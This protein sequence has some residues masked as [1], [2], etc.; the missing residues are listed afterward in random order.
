[1]A[2][3][4][5]AV[6]LPRVNAGTLITFRRAP[7]E[8]VTPRIQRVVDAAKKSRKGATLQDIFKS[9]KLDTKTAFQDTV[10]IVRT[11]AKEGALQ[12]KPA[13][14]VIRQAAGMPEPKV[15]PVSIGGPG[16]YVTAK[17]IAVAFSN[18]QTLGRLRR[19]LM[20]KADPRVTQALVRSGLLAKDKRAAVR[21]DHN[22][23]IMSGVLDRM[24]QII[25]GQAEVA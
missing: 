17:G 15:A 7:K 24:K 21:V 22:E 20:G 13:A 19:V 23:M 16:Y 10:W 2:K 3:K 4:T 25:G 6:E 14:D 12:L 11:L 18:E 1:M 9:L 8:D 5:T